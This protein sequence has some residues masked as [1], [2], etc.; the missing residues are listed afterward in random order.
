MRCAAPLAVLAMSL[1]FGCA[2]ARPPVDLTQMAVVRTI[3]NTATVEY[4]S[5]WSSVTFLAK[6]NEAIVEVVDPNAPAVSRREVAAPSSE[7]IVQA[8]A[9]PPAAAPPPPEPPQPAPASVGADA[10]GKDG[11]ESKRG[12]GASESHVGA[13]T[14][15]AAAPGKSSTESQAAKSSSNAGIGATESGAQRGA[16]S[17]GGGIGATTRQ[18]ARADESSSLGIGSTSSAAQRGE[19]ASGSARGDTRIRHVT[20]EVTGSRAVGH[21]KVTALRPE[22]TVEKHV[23]R[24]RVMSGY[25]L[26]FTLTIRNTGPLAV[27]AAIVRDELPDD[28]ALMDTEGAKRIK[29]GDHPRALSFRLSEPLPPKSEQI[30]TITT[31]VR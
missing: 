6:S 24:R 27:Q 22:L 12:G 29:D 7:P 19:A 14:Q 25:E 3:R 17:T 21:V 20:G 30:V 13:A 31:R 8:P 10:V 5:I 4:Q 18:F 2:P 1:P 16:I 23:D 15:S 28:L 9:P 26:T 11:F